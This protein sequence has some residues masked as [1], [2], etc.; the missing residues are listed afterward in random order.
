MSRNLRGEMV[1]DL[2]GAKLSLSDSRFI[3][4][5]ARSLSIGCKEVSRPDLL[6]LL[7]WLSLYSPIMNK[8]IQDQ[9]R[10]WLTVVIHHNI[11]DVLRSLKPYEMR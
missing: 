7:F 3:Q 6:I 11:I 4:V 2:E 1:A 5:I 10:L 8:H 9:K